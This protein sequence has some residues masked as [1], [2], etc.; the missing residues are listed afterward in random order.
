MVIM[1]FMATAPAQSVNVTLDT[2]STD[3][4]GGVGLTLNVP[5]N[6]TPNNF[7]IRNSTSLRDGLGSY[8]FVDPG[9]VDDNRYWWPSGQRTLGLMAQ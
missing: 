8:L 2:V 6:T 4:N 5:V 7:L 3:H 9:N 1:G